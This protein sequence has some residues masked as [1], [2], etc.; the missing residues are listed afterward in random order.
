MR[1]RETSHDYGVADAAR[2]DRRVRGRCWLRVVT[3]S[4]GSAKPQPAQSCL[5]TRAHPCASKLTTRL[6]GCVYDATIH[7]PLAGATVVLR[8]PDGRATAL[9][10]D[11]NGE[12][13]TEAAVD[14]GVEDRLPRP[15]R[16]AHPA[17]LSANGGASVGAAWP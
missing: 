1:D 16:S 11:A 5:T 14:D 7:E 12:W 9:L 3:A 8:A 13:G 4:C 17:R 6:H 2:Y 10:T 15:R